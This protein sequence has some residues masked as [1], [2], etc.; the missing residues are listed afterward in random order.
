MKSETVYL[1]DQSNAG[2]RRNQ[3]AQIIGISMC[4]PEGLEPRLCYNLIWS[5]GVTD[6]KPINEETYKVVTFTE[7]LKLKQ[8][9]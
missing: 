9:L 5:D 3:P 7:L 1:I 8:E 4:T 6:Y 2:F